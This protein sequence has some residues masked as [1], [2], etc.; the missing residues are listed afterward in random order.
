M[1][2][3]RSGDITRIGEYYTVPIGVI[4]G[5]MPVVLGFCLYQ[6]RV[7]GLF[8]SRFSCAMVAVAILNWL[9]VYG[10]RFSVSGTQPLF[11][12][13]YA[14]LMIILSANVLICMRYIDNLPA[15][16]TERSKL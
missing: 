11:F 8:F 6:Y 7:V 2:Y 1:P 12:C 3:G 13:C 15:C 4:F 14:A 9:P 16:R 10:D 5:L